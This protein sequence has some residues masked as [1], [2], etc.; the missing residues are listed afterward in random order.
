MAKLKRTSSEG[1]AAASN[2]KRGDQVTVVKK[3]TWHLPTHAVPDYRK[4]IHPGHQG[5]VEG[6]RDE[7]QSGVL[8]KVVVNM[9]HGKKL[10]TTQKANPGNLQLTEDYQNSSTLSVE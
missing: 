3:M 2:F 6:F 1:E 8:L 10:E 5:E 7:K 9:P 4:D